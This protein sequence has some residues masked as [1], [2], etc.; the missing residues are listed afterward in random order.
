MD[1][2]PLLPGLHLHWPWPI[3]QVFRIAVQQVQAVSVGHEGQEAE[4]PENVLWARQHAANEYTLL[5]GNGRDLWEFGV[6]SRTN[7][8]AAA[9]GVHPGM[10]VV[11]SAKVL[12]RAPAV[13]PDPDPENREV[14]FQGPNGHCVIATNSI[15]EAL[16]EDYETN[17]LCTAG[18]TGRSVI[19]YITGF[20]PYG[21]ICSDGSVGKNDSGLAALS[22]AN[23]AGIPG[24]SVSAA[25][26]RM[27]DGH[28]TYE[29]GVISAM[30]ELAA[31]AGVRLG[32]SAREAA[33]LLV[34]RDAG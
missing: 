13:L 25:S 33:K 21:F 9:L 12:A 7:A 17:V 15:A 26:A 3:D 31:A 2:Q 18:H 8:L 34:E 5:L 6:V 24:A 23:D 11:D 28:S 29:D 19:G 10:T 20:R 1:G 14:V 32:M 16:P 22:P 30:N 27:G 4:G